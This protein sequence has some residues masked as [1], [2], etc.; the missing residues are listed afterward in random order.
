MTQQTARTD[1]SK[2]WRGDILFTCSMLFACCILFTGMMTAPFWEFAERQQILSANATATGIAHAT[3][4]ADYAFIDPFNTNTEYWRS[5]A[6]DREYANG[7]ISIRGGIYM[8]EFREVK[9]PFL[10]WAPYRMGNWMEDF[11]VYVDTKIKTADGIPME[12]CSGFIFRT[13]SLDWE[14]GTYTFSVCNDSYFDVDY[15]EQGEWDVIS[16]WTYSE[17]IRVEEWNRLGVS[18]RGSHFTFLI[19][20]EIVFD[21]TDER[22]AKGGLGLLI[23]VNEEKPVSIWFDNFGLQRR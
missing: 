3:E 8:W 6:P 14:S 23:E 12:A 2:V 9:Q 7:S 19:N 21:M 4:Q 11:D 18:A 20:N 16:D 10:D 22:Q 15:Y 5:T 1:K 17:S 13:A